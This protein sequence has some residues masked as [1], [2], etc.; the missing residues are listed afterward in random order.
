MIAAVDAGIAKTMPASCCWM[1][2]E[3]AGVSMCDAD[4]SF[5]DNP[6]NCT[7]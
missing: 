1:E 3:S 2:L 7:S 5:S 4:D 6:A